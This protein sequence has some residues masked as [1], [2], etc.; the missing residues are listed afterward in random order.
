MINTKF[1]NTD[2]KT[3]LQALWIEVEALDGQRRIDRAGLMERIEDLED[4]LTKRVDVAINH[5]NRL[6]EL[7]EDALEVIDG[8]TKLTTPEKVSIWDFFKRNK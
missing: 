2:T 7:E 1:K 3:S 4:G 6:R 5:N 8:E